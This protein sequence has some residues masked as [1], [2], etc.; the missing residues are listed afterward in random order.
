MAAVAT[1]T[2]LWCG[3]SYERDTMADTDRGQVCSDTCDRALQHAADLYAESRSMIEYE[4]TDMP[5]LEGSQGLRVE[6][7]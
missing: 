1:M 6:S 2:C 7:I 4:A 5:R 3:K